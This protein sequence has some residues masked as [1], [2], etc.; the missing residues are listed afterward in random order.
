MPFGHERALERV[1]E[2]L[3]RSR[4]PCFLAV[5]KDM[6]P[7]NDAPLSFPLAGWTLALDLPRRAPGLLAALDRCDVIVVEAGG[8]VYLSKDARLARETV[9][10]M[11]PR[12]AQWRAAR[13]QADLERLWRSDLSTRTGLTG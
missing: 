9:E 5:L 4:V 3:R 1:L 12:L 13:E 11:Y 2:E 8:R 10:A 6:G 7:E